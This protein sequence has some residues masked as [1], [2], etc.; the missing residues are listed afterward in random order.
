MKREK[1]MLQGLE[2]EVWSLNT[3][4]VGTGAAGW[5]A[6]DSLVNLG[7]MDVA[8]ITEGVNMGTSRNTGSDKQTYYKLTLAGDE[9]DSIF[10]MA[11]TLFEGGSRHGDIALVEAALSARCFY[12]LV[13][14]GV[15][16]P[17]SRYGE[18]IGYKTDHDPRQRA[19]SI[20]PLTSRAM[21]EKLERQARLKGITIF[22]NLLV[23][24]ILTTEASRAIGLV[25]L[26]MDRLQEPSHGLT[27]FN[28]TNIIYATGGP[29]GIYEASVYPQSQTGAMGIAFEAGVKGVNLTES[30]YGIASTQFRWNLSGSYQQVIPRYVSTDQSGNNPLEFLDEYFPSVG[31]MLTAIFMKGYQWPFDPRKIANNGSSLID[32]LVYN[33]INNKGR[34]VFLDYRSNPERAMKDGHFDFSVLDEEAL[35][36]LERSGILFGS[37]IERLQKMNMPAIELYQRNG[38]DLAAQPL[39][40][41]VCA[42]H[43]NGG[44]EGDLWWES[45]ISHFFPVGEVNGSFGV[46]RPGGSALNSTQTGSLRAA[47]YIT[48]KYRQEPL[49]LE[50]FM[51]LAQRQ[52]ENKLVLAQRLVASEAVPHNLTEKIKA[53]RQRMTSSGAHVRNLANVETAISECYRELK[54]FPDTIGLRSPLEL[55]DAF[56]YY[57]ML[58]TQMLYL[59]AI[60]EY[61]QKG[62]QSRGSYLISESAGIL[63]AT[64]LA[65]S[66]RYRLAD[67]TL[68][69]YACE[70]SINPAED[71]SCSFTWTPVRP[72]P[73]EE[74]WFETLWTAYRAGEIWGKE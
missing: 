12:K 7:Q 16:F 38:I 23:I 29:A 30:Q 49:S 66:F 64:G 32:L 47:Q 46:Y 41:A 67:Q 61:I 56:R 40:I 70:A 58:I 8:I 42:Q 13:E 68:M 2:I 15:D 22:D 10:E 50:D 60:R 45:N 9:K 24:G 4:V 17:Y 3:V 52:A 26:D 20:G 1:V 36:Y 18:Y 51:R 25:A 44:L 57:D 72:I 11:K 43:S 14:I 54:A 33:E 71:W 5:N 31:A 37:P 28:C 62:G 53:L 48:Q 69:Q 55:P 74:Y 19:T 59:S 27:L 21:T 63:P 6:A 34:R 73:Q 35:Q 65:D 39:E